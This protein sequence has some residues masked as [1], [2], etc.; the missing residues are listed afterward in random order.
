MQPVVATAEERHTENARLE[1]TSI[2][3]LKDLEL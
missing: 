1:Q 2:A 3:A